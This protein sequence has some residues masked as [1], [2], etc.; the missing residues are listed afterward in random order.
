MRQRNASIDYIR[1]IAILLVLL[2]HTVSNNGIGDFADSGLYKIIFALQMPLFMLV[3]GYV[4]KYTKSLDTG[5]KLLSFFGRRSLGYLL[6]WVVWTFFRG[7]AFGGW[8]LGTL[9]P[10]IHSLFWNMDSGYWFLISLWTICIVWGIG[11]FLANKLSESN[12]LRV[13]LCVGFAVVFS[14]GLFFIGLKMGLSFFNIKLTLYYVPYFFLGYIFSSFYELFKNKKA[15][16]LVQTIV[17]ALSFIIFITI[18]A[19][20]NIFFL[21]ES[22]SGIVIRMICSLTGCISVIYFAV[23]FFEEFK[24]CLLIERIKSCITVIGRESL[25]FYLIHYMFLNIIR[26]PAGTSFYSFEA[27]E[28]CL[29]NYILTIILSAAM[30]YVINLNIML[31]TILFGKLKK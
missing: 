9:K 19:S 10:E 21:D 5:R 22:F 25:G 20:C 24:S 26:L 8:T 12:I 14:V 7:F 30:I 28:T 3:S 15:F 13:F 23:R 11:S 18:S 29:V 27:F 16:H 6:P 31:K 4:T 1:G 2:G 17:V